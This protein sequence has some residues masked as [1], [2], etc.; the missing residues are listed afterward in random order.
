VT[1]WFERSRTRN[2][3]S[4][5]DGVQNT[6]ADV[7]NLDRLRNRVIAAPVNPDLLE[8][9]AVYGEGIA[10]RASV[11]VEQLVTPRIGVRA[12]YTYTDSENTAH[13]GLLIPYLA[14][15]NANLGL[16]FSPGWRTFFTAQA[17]YRSRRFADEANFIALPAGWDVQANIFVETADKRWAVEA[18]AANLL[19]KETSDL[20]GIVVSYRF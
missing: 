16:S 17:V 12:H 6:R 20:F 8:D 4:P 9:I 15:H 10:R 3:V 19:K 14:R 1:A 2:L 5:L 13:A 11:A 18:Y 7:T